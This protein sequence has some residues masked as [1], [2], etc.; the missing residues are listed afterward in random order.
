VRILVCGGRNFSDREL[1][2]KTLD[3]V[4]DKH[5][6][7]MTII[8]GCATGADALADEWSKL[9]EIPHWCFP[10][11]WQKF[12]AKAGPIRNKRMRDL[13]NPT[14]CIA[15]PGGRGTLNMIGLMREVG[16]DPWLVG[17]PK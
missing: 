13:A 14:Q 17:W 1:V 8:H 6:G 12:G 16:V 11:E 5:G 4:L 9:R 10:A 7:Y 15:F 2:F 3:R